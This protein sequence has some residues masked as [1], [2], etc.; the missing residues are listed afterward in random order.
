MMDWLVR[1]LSSL[2]PA[3][4]PAPPPSVAPFD[5]NDMLVR[6]NRERVRHGDGG[7]LMLDSSLTA[8]AR[9]RSA[10][11]ALFGITVGHLHDGFTT[12]PFASASGENAAIGQVDAVEVMT[13]WM[14]DPGHRIN[15]LE[16]RFSKMGA[17]R[18]L[19][20]DGVPYWYTVFSG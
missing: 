15:I 17:A 16:A 19:S 18:T 20:K 10:H 1:L 11:A 6:H 3:S 14:S 9:E 12:L 5:A 8:I 7:P 13:T 4:K 2:W